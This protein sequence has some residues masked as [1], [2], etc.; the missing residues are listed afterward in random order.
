M[1]QPVWLEISWELPGKKSTSRLC[2]KPGFGWLRQLVS[3]LN[4]AAGLLAGWWVGAEPTGEK[5][6][7]G[8]FH[9]EKAKFTGIS[10]FMILIWDDTCI[11]SII[12]EFLILRKHIWFWGIL[13]EYSQ[14]LQV[15]DSAGRP[16]RPHWVFSLMR[17]PA[18][19]LQAW[20]KILT[21]RRVERC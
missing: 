18:N 16:M 5:T 13:W 3:P 12:H 4:G 9:N 2:L 10:G 20:G 14:I 8:S 15:W 17:R 6:R 19:S 7:K 1:K 21:L 11:I